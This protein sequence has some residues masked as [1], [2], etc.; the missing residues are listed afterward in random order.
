MK[1]GRKI[2]QL[3]KLAGMTQEQLSEKLNVSRQT[4]SKWE[5]DAASPD[6]ESMVKFS[7]MFQISLDELLLEEAKQME[8]NQ[9]AQIT[10][11][12]L[13]KINE[14][15]RRMNL[16][17]SSGILF[18]VVGVM[19]LSFVMALET[20]TV[21]TTYILYR[22]MTVGEY[23]SAP[24]NYFRLMIPGIAVVITGIILCIIYVRKNRRR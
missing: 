1:L 13:T 12:D 22:Y 16:L 21:N 20:I 14:Q 15:S 6:L 4:V 24:V 10:L 19:M 18:T 23:A 3:R 8:E 2:K 9:Q 7:V 5:A 11:E 17:L